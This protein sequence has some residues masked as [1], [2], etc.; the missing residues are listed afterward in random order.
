M[1][2]IEGR[3]SLKRQRIRI[4]DDRP[5]QKSSKE[6][7]WIILRFIVGFLIIG[8]LQTSFLYSQ[9]E[10]TRHVISI[11]D[12]SAE[13]RQ[14]GWTKE[15]QLGDWAYYMA[16]SSTGILVILI[17]GTTPD[18]RT[19]SR[20]LLRRW[21]R[22]GG[23]RRNVKPKIVLSSDTEKGAPKTTT[24]DSTSTTTSAN[25]TQIRESYYSNDDTFDNTRSS[26]VPILQAPAS[27][28]IAPNLHPFQSQNCRLSRPPTDTRF[29]E[30]IPTDHINPLMACRSAGTSYED[31]Y[32]H[33]RDSQVSFDG[34]RPTRESIQEGRSRDVVISQYDYRKDGLGRNGTLLRH[35]VSPLTP[36]IHTF[37]RFRIQQD[38]AV[39][40]TVMET[41]HASSNSSYSSHPSSVGAGRCS[42]S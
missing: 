38:P 42:W 19:Q 36:E 21:F 39:P 25:V 18:S 5:M 41:D 24:S 6:D 13:L 22:C 28:A 9:Y 23:F 32:Y 35:C 4:Q 3:R 15:R 10:Y 27:V 34:V 1:V 2:A 7:K 16:S 40:A 33:N 11:R 8:A 14:G 12:P 30:V 29:P 26:M 31:E 17:F 37:E 20:R